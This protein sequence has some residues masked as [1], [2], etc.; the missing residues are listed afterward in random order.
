MTESILKWMEDYISTDQKVIGVAEVDNRIGALRTMFREGRGMSGDQLKEVMTTA[1]F[2]TYF[3]DAL[4]RM[5]YKDYEYVVGTWR[6]YTYQDQTPDFRNVDRF[7]MSEPG[8]LRLRREKAESKTTHIEAS[9]IYYSVDE[10]SEQFDVSWHTIM[11]DDLSKIRETPQR[12]A[13]AAARFE[14]QF[15]SALY[16]NAVTQAFIAGLGAPWAG[17]GRLTAAN[18][19]VGIN[20]MSVRTDIN[21]NQMNINKIHLVIPTVLR[22]QAGVI[23]RSELMAGV[24]TNDKNILSEYIAGVHVDPYIATAGINVPWYLFADPAEIPTVTVARLNG[25]DRPWT[26]KKKSDVEPMS[27]S[28]PA[29]FMM[30]SFAT[31]DIEYGV[32]DIIGG[33]ADASYVGVTDFRGLFYSSGTTP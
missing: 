10:Y 14:D 27:G 15:V 7:R 20:A 24:A 8:T 23:L 11:N 6:Q 9:R 32:S 13:K 30:G 25:F 19:A 5:F 26:Y 29:P 1:H 12:M 28:A 21:G 3:A 4:S 31:G 16:D 33:W 22:M 18:L 17:T 2:A